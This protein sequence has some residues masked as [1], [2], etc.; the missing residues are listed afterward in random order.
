[1]NGQNAY[2]YSKDYAKHHGLNR[3][4]GLLTSHAENN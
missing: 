2:I 3:T 1:M 4:I